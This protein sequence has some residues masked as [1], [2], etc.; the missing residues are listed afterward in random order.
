M[1]KILCFILIAFPMIV[2]GQAR[3]KL[4]LKYDVSDFVMT[5]SYNKILHITSS[6]YPYTL[7]EDVTKPALP[8]IGINVLI[9]ENMDYVSHTY[10]YHENL[11]KEDVEIVHN[12]LPVT[13]N[14]TAS[15]VEVSEKYDEAIYPSDVLEYTGTH[16]MGGYRILCFSFSP[17]KYDVL[18][19]KVYFKS[20]VSL[21]ISLSETPWKRKRSPHLGMKDAV[22]RMVVNSQ[23]LDAYY[24][25]YVYSPDRSS[26]T[27]TQGYEYLIVTCD[28]LEDEFQRL[29]D[30]K[31]RKGVRAKV[32]TIEDITSP[33]WTRPQLKIKQ[34]IK[35]FYDD[36]DNTLRYVLLGGDHEIIPAEH[37]NAICVGEIEDIASDLFY[38]SFTNMDWDTNGNGKIGEIADNIDLSH[39]LI[40]TRLSVNSINDARCQIDRILDYERIPK[41]DNW[42]DNIIMC[43]TRIGLRHWYDGVW[44]SDAHYKGNMLYN[45]YIA[46]R[47]PGVQR[48]ILYDTGS[49]FEGGASYDFSVNNLQDQITNG[50]TFLHVDT[51]G[52]WDRW[53]V[54]FRSNAPQYYEVPDARSA[55][56]TGHT[57]VV[58][59]ACQTNGFSAVDTCLSEAFMRNS[60]SGMI[61]YYGCTHYGWYSTDS[62]A[63]GP[64]NKFNGEM[65]K[66]LLSSNSRQLGSAVYNSKEMFEYDSYSDNTTRWLMFGLN[67]LGDPE[68]PVFLSHPMSFENINVSFS[69]GEL[70][71][72]TGVPDCRI[73]VMSL[74]DGGVYYN[75]LDSVN[76]STFQLSAGE[77]S[78]CVTKTGYIPYCAIVGNAVYVQNETISSNVDIIANNVYMGSDVTISKPQG[79]VKVYNGK[80]DVRASGTVLIPM[81]FE[82]CN[83]AE[84]NIQT[85][86]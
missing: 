7:K 23:D 24:G 25:N 86:N 28:S 63:L 35:D 56:N 54:E 84:L 59:S 29:A 61:A 34:A 71:V 20:N 2:L 6:V 69:N 68:M 43:G 57:I 10:T 40:V 8:Y 85:G 9:P 51:H 26:S 38:A 1:K 55:S 4:E 78:L 49:S 75:V 50:Y 72:N 48:Y 15:S 79:N 19:R 37:C 30:W 53:K 12:S 60:N 39:D 16:L 52:F 65:Y 18:N 82:V 41:T 74:N 14:S 47:W 76:S 62:M 27:G 21:D 22:M 67:L 3:K 42:E 11:V 44:M 36:P 13:D 83:G 31:T 73:C 64:S 46:G 80:L 33:Q 45:N 5:E 77:Y 32:I 66:T 81:G 17:F 58:T 70:S